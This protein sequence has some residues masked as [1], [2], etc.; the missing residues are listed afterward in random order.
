MTRKPHRAI[1]YNY[2][3]ERYLES[4][5]N[6]IRE[7]IDGLKALLKERKINSERAIIVAA[8]ALEE[9]FKS[10]MIAQY[11]R[12][13]DFKEFREKVDIKTQEYMTISQYEI[14]HKQLQ[15]DTVR[16]GSLTDTKVDKSEFA[17]YKGAVLKLARDLETGEAVTKGRE[18]SLPRTI[19]IAAATGISVVIFSSLFNH[20]FK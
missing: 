6:T 3:S 11:V 15:D 20:F 4:E 19:L 18:G 12:Q 13:Q 8:D 5:L 14:R 16:I 2:V 17:D 7:S 1:N 10:E 9:K